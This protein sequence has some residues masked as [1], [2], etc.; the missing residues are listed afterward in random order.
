MCVIATESRDLKHFRKSATV[1]CYHTVYCKV[2]RGHL[3]GRAATSQF[4]LRQFIQVNNVLLLRPSYT[5]MH[6]YLQSHMKVTC[7]AVR[8][9]L[10]PDGRQ[11]WLYTAGCQLIHYLV[12][13]L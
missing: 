6:L 9:G 10:V 2:T 13:V 1:L 8:L 7:F 3:C 4:S 12:N 5:V 11:S